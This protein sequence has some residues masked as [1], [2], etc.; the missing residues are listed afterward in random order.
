[1]AGLIRQTAPHVVSLTEVDEAWG[2]ADSLHELADRDGYAWLFV[3]SFEFG[4]TA[5]SGGFGNALLALLSLIVFR[6]VAALLVA[7][8]PPARE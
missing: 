8:S 5:P 2:M 1:M 4:R 6:G 7:S 3:P